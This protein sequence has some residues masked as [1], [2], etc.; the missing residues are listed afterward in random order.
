MAKAKVEIGKAEIEVP[1]NGESG[2][3]DFLNTKHAKIT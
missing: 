1:N 3:S 2:Y